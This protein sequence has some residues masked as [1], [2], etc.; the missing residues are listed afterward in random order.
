[1]I[2]AT[3]VLQGKESSSADTFAFPEKEPSLTAGE[4]HTQL[5]N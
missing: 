2:K 3:A 5:A 4:E 1:M